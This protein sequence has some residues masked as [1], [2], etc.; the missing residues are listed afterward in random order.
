MLTQAEEGLEA[1]TAS[2]FIGR[3]ILQVT[4]LGSN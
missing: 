1:I 3:V 4:L 2:N